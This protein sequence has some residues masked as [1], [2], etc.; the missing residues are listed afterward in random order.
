[1]GFFGV[2][3]RDRVDKF[4]TLNLLKKLLKESKKLLDVPNYNFK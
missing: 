2:I 3:S 4:N 1:M